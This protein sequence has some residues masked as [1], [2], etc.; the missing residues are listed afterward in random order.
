MSALTPR[1]NELVKKKL[2][3]IFKS[4][5]FNITIEANKKSVNFL[6]VNFNLETETYKPYMKP[7]QSPVYVHMQSNHPPSILKNIPA[8]VNRRLSSISANEEVFKGAIAPY[9]EALKNS[10]YNFELKFDPPKNSEK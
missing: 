8:S 1:Q 2:C 10:G 5:G 4:N 3:Q 6:D 9:Q 7:N